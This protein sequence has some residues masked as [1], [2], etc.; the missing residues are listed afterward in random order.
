MIVSMPREIAM[1]Q[2]FTS[3]VLALGVCMLLIGPGRAE[4]GQQAPPK[5]PPMTNG[6]S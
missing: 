3:S 6:G 1:T 5:Q 4:A 2:S